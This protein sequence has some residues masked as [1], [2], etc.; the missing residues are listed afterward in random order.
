MVLLI[1]AEGVVDVSLQMDGEV[2][3]PEQRPGDVDEPLDELLSTLQ[4]Q[5]ACLYVER[6]SFTNI[7]SLDGAHTAGFYSSQK[8]TRFS[9]HVQTK[10]LSTIN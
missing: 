7:H 5:D 6:T 3:D 4:R 1:W 9:S 10:K 8:Q 2:R